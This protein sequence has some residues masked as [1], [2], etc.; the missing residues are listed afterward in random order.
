[1]NA[2]I[3]KVFLVGLVVVELCVVAG[4]WFWTR[5]SRGELSAQ[6]DRQASLEVEKT[7]LQATIDTQKAYR[8]ALTTD[9]QFL[10]QVVREKL[11]YAATN[12]WVFI[13]EEQAPAFLESAQ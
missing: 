9:R 8:T 11:E 4:F 7:H 10:E 6:Q 2:L 12:E 1:M 3:S 13:I 5:E